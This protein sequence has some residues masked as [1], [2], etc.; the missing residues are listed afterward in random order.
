MYKEIDANKRKS[1]FIMVFF[2]A[3]ASAIAYI[4]GYYAGGKSFAPY[5]I[6]AAFAYTLF[7]Y[8]AG[9]KMAL[10]LNG[11]HEITKQQEP[12]LY[13]TVENLAITNGMPMPKV[14]VIEDAGLNAFATGRDPNHSAVCA[15]RGLLNSLTDVELQGVM[16]HELGHVKNYDIRVSLIAFALAS[17]IGIISD[18]VLR[19]WFWG[20]S[21]DDAPSN[22]VFMAIGVV[23][24][25]LSPFVAML[26]QLAISRRREYLAD[27]TGALTTRYPEGLA[28]ALEKLE[29]QG[30]ALKRQSSS[31]AHLFFANP[32]K[33]KTLAGLFSTH[34]PI[35]DR[36][37]RLR[38]MG[39]GG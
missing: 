11:A 16:A 2:V 23:A 32:L 13:R 5:A 15:T 30:S 34:P 25:L 14:Y 7:S 4:G 36:I 28:S 38:Q 6:I 33:G 39:Q 29:Q 21:D 20:G 3:F 1:A 12:R 17:I 31:T 10:A 18:L 19:M 37:A 8:F 27:A 22:P 9:A 35:Q 26:I 24:I